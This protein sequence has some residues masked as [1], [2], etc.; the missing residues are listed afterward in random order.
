MR[1]KLTDIFNDPR[2]YVHARRV[3]DTSVNAIYELAEKNTSKKRKRKREV[4]SELEDTP[5]LTALKKCLADI[6]LK[7][8]PY[9]ITDVVVICV[10]DVLRL[11]QEAAIFMRGPKNSDINTLAEIVSFLQLFLYLPSNCFSRNIQVTDLAPHRNL[12]SWLSAYTTVWLG[13]IISYIAAHSMSCCP[14]T[15]SKNSITLS[16]VLRTR[17]LMN[18]W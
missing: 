4:V 16:L 5:D 13:R 12:P 14:L 15:L 11:P 3:H 6:K 18:T 10:G 1:S 9:V 17:S 8:W 7:S 2:L